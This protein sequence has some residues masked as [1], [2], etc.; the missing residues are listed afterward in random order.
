MIMKEYV[1]V[2]KKFLLLQKLKKGRWL[3]YMLDT[4]WAKPNDPSHF[5]WPIPIGDG[6]CVGPKLSSTLFPF[7]KRE[8]MAM[9][10]WTINMIVFQ[11]KISWEQIYNLQKKS[12]TLG[13]S[14]KLKQILWIQFLSFKLADYFELDIYKIS[15]I[16]CHQN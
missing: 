1:F 11:E 13:H 15:F 4:H 8:G 16:F 9:H 7:S 10:K 5:G 14:K 3:I 6:S 2:S 12:V